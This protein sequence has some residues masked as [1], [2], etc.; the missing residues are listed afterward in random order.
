MRCTF[1]D[2]PLESS[3]EIPLILEPKVSGNYTRY[4]IHRAVSES[5][6]VQYYVGIISRIIKSSSG[7]ILIPRP[8]WLEYTLFMKLSLKKSS[9]NTTL[10][11]S[12]V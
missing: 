3:S 8:Y 12:V 2:H 9:F 10:V 4:I 5:L 11:L 6:F 1:Y 7:I